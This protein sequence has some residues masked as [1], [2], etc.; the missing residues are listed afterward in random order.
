MDTITVKLTPETAKYFWDKKVISENWFFQTFDENFTN[1][2]ELKKLFTM[3]K[4]IQNLWLELTADNELYIPI[5]M[6]AKEFLN[7]MKKEVLDYNEK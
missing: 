7:T 4:I 6:E 5:K 3:Q 2:W 1:F